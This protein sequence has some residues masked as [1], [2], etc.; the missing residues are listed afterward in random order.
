MKLY[1]DSFGGLIQQLILDSESDNLP[2]PAFLLQQ[3]GKCEE[4]LTKAVLD[5][6]KVA[7]YLKSKTKKKKRR[8]KSRMRKRSIPSLSESS[9]KLVESSKQ[10]QIINQ[11]Q[12]QPVQ[13]K[14]PKVYSSNKIVPSCIPAKKTVL[15]KYFNRGC[16]KFGDRC[17]YSH[18]CNPNNF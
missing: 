18:E 2:N 10:Q 4:T 17:K 3:L 6:P 9:A 13:Q 11:K 15:C 14:Q 7:S 5:A 16:C 8:K 12:Q 1:F